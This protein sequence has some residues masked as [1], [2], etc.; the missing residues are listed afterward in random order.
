MNL[1]PAQFLDL[2]LS[3]VVVLFLLSIL[4]PALVFLP[5]RRMARSISRDLPE[6]RLNE[7]LS[8]AVLLLSITILLQVLKL[9]YKTE[10]F[11]ALTL[12]V[13]LAAATGALES[14]YRLPTQFT[15]PIRIALVTFAFL[16]GFGF[17]PSRIVWP[18]FLLGPLLIDF[19]VSLMFYAGVI[20]SVGV[21]DR[22]RGLASGVTMIIAFSLVVLM[23]NWS[24]GSPLL[25]MIAIAGICTGHLLLN[26]NRRHLRLGTPGQLQ[27][28]VFIAATTISSRTWGFTLA[29]YFITLMA[30]A[31]P[32]IDRIYSAIFRFSEGSERDRGSH[33]RSLLLNIGL[34]ERYV[35]FTIWLITLVL[36][37]LV[38]VVYEAESLT[39]AIA[40]GLSILLLVLYL[41]VMLIRVGE[42]LE[43]SRDPEHLRIL[44]LS[45]YF[46][47]EVN[48]PASRLY[49]H[50]RYWTRA[51]HQVTVICPVPSAP[52][53][54]PYPGFNNPFW[55]E[56]VVDGIRVIRV[57]TFI[58]ANKRR[59]RRTINYLSF[60]FT[61]LL[62][63]ALL[64]RHDCLIATSPQ[65]FCGLAG[66]LASLFRR[67]KF[68]LE[69]RDIWPDSIEAV[70]AARSSA[71][72]RIIQR[73]AHWMY[74]R[75][76]LIVT[77]GEGY[78]QKIIQDAAVDPA[79]ITVVPNGIDFSIFHPAERGQRHLLP[80][81]GIADQF[82]VAYVGTVGL[83][84]GLD[85][86]IRAGTLLRDDNRIILL[87][88]GDGAQ[89]AHLRKE[90]DD[91]GL[92]NVLFTGLLPK[93]QIPDIIAESDAC[94][95][96]LKR[97]ELFRTVLPSKIFEAMGM[98]RPVILG[99]EGFSRDLLLE[100]GGGIPIEPENAEQLADA[101]RKLAANPQLARQLG[102]SGLEFVRTRYTREIF[103]RRYID[104][105][106]D[107]TLREDP[108]GEPLLPQTDT[109]PAL[110]PGESVRHT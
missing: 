92:A 91:A 43:R 89:L 10:P 94:L 109:H 36:G 77:V 25:L 48:A 59:I 98:G 110:P 50:A 54:W 86:V 24:F 96:H 9:F 34:T 102:N 52:H 51:G 7:W 18:H 73:L 41:I 100:S 104:L 107:A 26:S 23:L 81:H 40:T 68:L 57:W 78:R 30:I 88:V 55:S 70:G 90:A 12:L 6:P 66:A 20:T 99:V 79:R 47:P 33:L 87:V 62:A 95:V 19:P 21:L 67:E 22:L 16:L 4:L 106:R 42:R 17:H 28:G 74:S 3:R 56:E 32:M 64:R 58:A 97:R 5:L 13:F 108:H 27:L 35:V 85:V 84:H 93:N 38:N 46:H 101:I 61:S 83:A 65:F 82:V 14:H 8:G 39:L 103:A 71:T 49:E 63:V 37:V 15:I 60:M 2:S 69:I 76:D 11:D 80:K 44:F 31:V 105:I 1:A 45:H 53:G 29:I 75:A 72:I